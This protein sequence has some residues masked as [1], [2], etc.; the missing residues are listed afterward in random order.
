MLLSSRT[1]VP[2]LAALFSLTVG[3]ATA[4]AQVKIGVVDLQLAISS[5][6]DGKAAKETLEEMT[7]KK[8]K[9]L[10]DKVES[11]KKMEENIQ[12]QLPLLSEQGKKDML[13]KYR[14]EMQELQQ[15]YID[16]QTALA[17]KKA[18][19]LEPILKK[20]GQV[21]QD[22][23]LSDGYTV[24]LDKGDGTVLYNAPAIDLTNEVIKKYN[25]K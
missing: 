7:K 14:K 2:V 10:D 6:K 20:M 24:I 17:R 13:E 18:E 12:K 25:A 9:E 5:T 19:L 21:I 16:N 8:Q 15:L 4:V 1:L 3:M 11:I 22:I 23:A